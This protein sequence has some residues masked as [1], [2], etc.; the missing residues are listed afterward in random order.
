[1]VEKMVSVDVNHSQI[2]PFLS[3]VYKA[4]GDISKQELIQRFVSVEFNRFLDYYQNAGD[5]NIKTSKATERPVRTKRLTDRDT[6]S[7]FINIGRRDNIREGA[8][9]RLVCDNAGI[10]SNKI[11][12]IVLNRDFSFFDIDKRVAH[13]V[14]KSLKGAKLDDRKIDIR[15]ADKPKFRHRKRKWRRKKGSSPNS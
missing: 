8:I 7:F 4:L 3:P 13:K 11:G 12:Q 5:L 2:D 10:R 9:V 14:L 6:Q 15:Y 1:M